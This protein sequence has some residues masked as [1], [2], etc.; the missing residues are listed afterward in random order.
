MPGQPG[1]APGVARPRIRH[2]FGAPH[3]Q[4]HWGVRRLCL[5]GHRPAARPPGATFV[6]HSTIIEDPPRSRPHQ[7]EAA[8]RNEAPRHLPR[9]STR[10]PTRP[11]EGR[12]G[13]ERQTTTRR[14][15]QGPAPQRGESRRRGWRH[16]RT[17]SRHGA[18]GT[19]TG[20]ANVTPKRPA[21]GAEMPRTLGSGTPRPLPLWGCGRA[22][23]AAACKAASE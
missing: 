5:P 22:A 16:I 11:P 18:W 1:A 21:T 15:G 14:S 2:R 7:L 10:R 3:A 9:P 12:R 8:P 19:R 17:H 23:K 4:G 20:P 13:Q 6:G